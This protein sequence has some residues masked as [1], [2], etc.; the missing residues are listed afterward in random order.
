MN[1]LIKF[2][3]YHDGDKPN[4]EILKNKF[5]KNN[6]SLAS[7]LIYTHKKRVFKILQQHRNGKIDHSPWELIKHKHSI[8]LVIKYVV[9]FF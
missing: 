3:H 4:A 6:Y 7:I 2:I 8:N 1:Y 9:K 5:C